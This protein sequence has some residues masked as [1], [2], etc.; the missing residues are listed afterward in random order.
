MLGTWLSQSE[1]TAV[2]LGSCL[3]NISGVTTGLSLLLTHTLVVFSSLS[4]VR[5]EN[6]EVKNGRRLSGFGIRHVYKD[7]VAF[8]CSPDHFLNGSSVVTCEA[9]STWKPPLP[10]CDP[11]E[12]KQVYFLEQ[13]Q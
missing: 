1:R 7:T 10:T 4:V 13:L 9:D 6:P 3:H 12:S 2:L 11:C 8:E 5:C